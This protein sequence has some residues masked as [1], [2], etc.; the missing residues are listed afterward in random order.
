[1]SS[2]RHPKVLV[3]GGGVAAAE[4]LIALRA[5]LG[6]MVELIS[7]PSSWRC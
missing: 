2:H 3:T 7:G 4:T 5:Q 6:S 1:M